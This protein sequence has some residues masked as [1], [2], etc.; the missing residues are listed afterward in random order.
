LTLAKLAHPQWNLRPAAYDVAYALTAAIENLDLVRARLLCEIVYKQGALQSFEQIHEKMQ[1][2]ITFELGQRFEKLRAWIEA[3]Q[4]E[5]AAA[6]DL[7]LSRLF[8][9]LLSQKHFGFHQNLNA[10]ATAAKLIDSARDFRQTVSEIEPDIDIAPEYVKMVDRGLI[11]NTYLREWT[12]I[13]D[14]AV[15]VAPA[16][17]YLMSNR[18]VDYQFWLNVGSGGWGLRLH[19]PL[20]HQYVM[21]R[22]WPAGRLWTDMDEQQANDEALSTLTLGLLRRCR[23]RVYLGFSQ[24]GEQG[25]EQRGPLLVAV[26]RMLRRLAN[27]GSNVP[28]AS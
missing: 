13:D 11:G 16:H 24:Y 21:S 25:I 20:T 6:L 10:A 23:K 8:G 19:Q 12:G 26:Q 5:D 9:E 4:Q 2:R 28:A 1:N 7:F 14:Q 17:T 18:P 27:E 3:Y 22:Q 15:L